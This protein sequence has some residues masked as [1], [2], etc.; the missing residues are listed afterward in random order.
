MQKNNIL[1][2]TYTF[3]SGLD[4]S[5]STLKSYIKSFWFDVFTPLHS[6]NSDIH[7]M[8]MCVPKGVVGYK[9]VNTEFKTIADLRRVNFSDRELFTR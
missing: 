3:P 1:N 2:K 6:N 4:I 7:L 5:P 9:V 8:L